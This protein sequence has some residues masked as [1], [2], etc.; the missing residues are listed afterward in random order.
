MTTPVITALACSAR[1][2]GNTYELTDHCLTLLR[3][4]PYRRTR[5]LNFY[6]YDVRVCHHCAYQCLTGDACPQTDDVAWLWEY[7]WRSDAVI[8]AVPTYGGLPPALWLAF[9]ERLQS[10]WQQAP[11]RRI[12]LAIITVANP[13]GASGG[14]LTADI[15]RR[16]AIDPWW[17]LVD[18][19]TFSPHAYGLRSE[20]GGLLDLPS[21]RERLGELTARLIERL[22]ATAS[23]S[24]GSEES[25]KTPGAGV[26]S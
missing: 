25:D 6:E 21:V 16:Q 3:D 7:T 17:D 4:G 10:L 9:M 11:A 18:A 1:R 24:G 14:E 23:E 22:P 12:P 26:Q 19:A 15:L 8:W 2:R 13:E 20:E 5:L